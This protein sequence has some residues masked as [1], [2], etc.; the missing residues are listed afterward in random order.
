MWSVLLLA[1]FS[2]LILSNPAK[3]VQR[4][5]RCTFVKFHRQT[6]PVGP[7]HT[8]RSPGAEASFSNPPSPSIPGP[9]PSSS[10][11]SASRV[12]AFHH[13]HQSDDE[14]ILGPSPTVPTMADALYGATPYSFPPL[15]PPNDINGED[16]DYADK[17]RAQAELFGSTRSA[18]PASSSSLVSPNLYDPRPPSSWLGW[19]QQDSTDAYQQEQQPH[20]DLISDPAHLI[21][22][23]AHHPPSH[24][25]IS[26]LNGNYFYFHSVRYA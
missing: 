16:T 7:G 8:T 14:F 15:Y 13:P 9:P 21:S 5:Y 24:S 4:R 20:T 22:D 19:G 17:Y 26:S 25:P 12:P 3:C 6:A 1:P 10:A 23:S 18:V 2:I 11:P